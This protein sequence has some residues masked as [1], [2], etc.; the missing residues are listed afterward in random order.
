MKIKK[1]KNGLIKMTAE[2]KDD[3]F[4]LTEMLAHEAGKGSNFAKLHEEK[5]NNHNKKEQ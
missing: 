4:K 1:H 3:S 5:I 2:S